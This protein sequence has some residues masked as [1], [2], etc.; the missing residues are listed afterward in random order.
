M[1]LKGDDIYSAISILDSSRKIMEYSEGFTE[2]T[3]LEDSRTLDAITFNL[4]KIG[5]ESHNLSDQFKGK[6]KHIDWWLLAC[7]VVNHQGTFNDEDICGILFDEVNGGSLI[8]DFK[9]IQE[10]ETELFEYINSGELL[11]HKMTIKE[12]INWKNSDGKYFIVVWIAILNDSLKS[13]LDKN[14]ITKSKIID[15]WKLHDGRYSNVESKILKINSDIDNWKFSLFNYR[16]ALEY[17][18]VESNSE[19]LKH[20]P[21]FENRSLNGATTIKENRKGSDL[22]LDTRYPYSISTSNSI[23]TVKKK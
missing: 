14:T 19:I 18:L 6:Y 3:I 23:W 21:F 12:F 2:E 7:L 13:N 4:I 10:L 17:M 5:N 11:D 22:P 1:I 8:N 9:L 16:K 20:L 15:A